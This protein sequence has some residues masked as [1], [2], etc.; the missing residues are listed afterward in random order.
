MVHVVLNDD[1]E[2]ESEPNVE[3]N[4]IFFSFVNSVSVLKLLIG[5]T[6]WNF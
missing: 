1:L 3:Q 2:D 4:F 6:G 5:G